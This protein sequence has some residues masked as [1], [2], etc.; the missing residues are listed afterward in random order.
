MSHLLEILGKGLDENISGVLSGHLRAGL[1]KTLPELQSAVAEGGC[2]HS[3]LELGLGLLRAA[4][5]PEAVDALQQALRFDSQ[6]LPAR[7]ALA[8]AYDEQGQC[9]QALASLKVANTTHPGDPAVLFAIGYSLERLQKPAEAAGYYR[10]AIAAKADFTQA[11][12]RLAAVALQQ[13][14]LPEAIAQQEY[15]RKKDPGDTAALAALGNLYHRAGRYDDAI[16]AYE[17]VIAMEPDNWALVDDEVELLVEAGQTREAIERLYQLLEIQGPFA[18]LHMRLA[19]LLSETGQDDPATHHYRQALQADPN[20]L[21]AR[22]RLARHHLTNGR[23]E[24]ACEGF[25]AATEI[26]DNL[27]DCYVG[28]GVAQAAAG[29]SAQAVETFQLA[30]AV[31]PNSTVLLTEMAKL[32]LKAAV[33][34]EFESQL[35]RQQETPLAEPDLDHDDLFQ[36]QL[37]RHAE[38]VQKHPGHAD[39][40]YRYGVLL[41]ADGRLAEAAEQF[42]TA[43]DINP[44]YVAAITRLGVTL[45][46]LGQ[47]DEAIAAFRQAL[48]LRHDYVDLH[49]RL[50]VLYTDRRQMSRAVEHLEQASGL[51]PGNQQVRIS[52]ALSLQNL[53]LMDRSAATWR[54]LCEMHKAAKVGKP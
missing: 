32:Q 34:A 20:Y 7:L 37:A 24:E 19:D 44:G 38:Y 5:L 45:Q 40:H 10:D 31:E 6:L 21:E 36:S 27:L 15:L 54:S 51:A 46:D 22:I 43:V 18:D 12:Q 47:T 13:E 25:Q 28:L 41:R 26:N 8:C 42:Q 48:E 14:N 16:E 1:G 53:G 35:D 33:A 9:D 3:Q 50:A 11:R 49:Y 29:R 17:T 23:W 52:L 2:A 39:A 4:Q 30:G